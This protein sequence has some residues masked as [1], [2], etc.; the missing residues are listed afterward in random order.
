MEKIPTDN[1]IRAMLDPVSP[2]ALCGLFDD[3]L[4]ALEAG[5]GLSDLRRLEGRV[6]TALD[7]TEHHCS[8]KIS[9][10]RCSRAQ[11]QRRGC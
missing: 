7:G 11:A 1:H 9:C 10:P 2:E 5:G 3:T 6:L 4:S 8:R